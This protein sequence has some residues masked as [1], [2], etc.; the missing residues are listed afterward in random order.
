MPL[1]TRVLA[2]RTTAH[3][4]P[5]GIPCRRLRHTATT[6][7][8]GRSFEHRGQFC[9]YGSLF[10]KVVIREKL[11]N[12]NSVAKVKCFQLQRACWRPSWLVASKARLLVGDDKNTPFRIMPR[13]FRLLPIH[14]RPH[15]V[16]STEK[17]TRKTWGRHVR[18]LS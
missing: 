5:I 2:Q 16:Q 7:E 17:Q 4:S 10:P 15:R 14:R 12:E 11:S 13:A 18:S 1:A 6:G 9:Y 3:R 8:G